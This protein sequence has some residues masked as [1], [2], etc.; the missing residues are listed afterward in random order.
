MFTRSQGDDL[1]SE[2]PPRR[3]GHAQK[4]DKTILVRVSLHDVIGSISG[5]IAYD[6]PSF[7]KHR[8]RKH[9]L[10]CSFNIGFFIVG[11]R[12]KNVRAGLPLAHFFWAG[13]R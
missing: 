10:N 7:R 1:R 12:H 9:A 4:A 13:R 6:Q 11:S 2:I 5:I 3:P 8:L